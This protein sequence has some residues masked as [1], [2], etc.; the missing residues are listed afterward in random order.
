VRTK[1]IWRRE[2][3]WKRKKKENKAPMHNKPSLFLLSPLIFFSL[4]IYW[5]CITSWFVTLLQLL[6]GNYTNK[7][8]NNKITLLCFFGLIKLCEISSYSSLTSWEPCRCPW[9]LLPGPGLSEH[10]LLR[11]SP[12]NGPPFRH[13]GRSDRRRV[14]SHQTMPLCPTVC[15]S[16]PIYQF[17]EYQLVQNHNL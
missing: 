7:T 1:S 3:K 12:V 10:P 13:S 9:L 17:L 2:K 8:T 14:L 4:S 11:C 15:F 16:V 6:R 5:F